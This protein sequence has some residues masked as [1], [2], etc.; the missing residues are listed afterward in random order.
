[1]LAGN[2]NLPVPKSQSKT[3]SERVSQ[4]QAMT[5]ALSI[6]VR[7]VNCSNSVTTSYPACCSTSLSAEAV[8]SL[9]IT[10]LINIEFLHECQ[11]ALKHSIGLIGRGGNAVNIRD[12]CK[13]H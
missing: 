8:G 13:D 7:V 11:A 6:L 4:T 2:S 5:A 10:Q 12:L 9:E 3:S 1:M